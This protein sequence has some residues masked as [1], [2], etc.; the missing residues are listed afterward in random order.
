M[1]P[2]TPHNAST[3][4]WNLLRGLPYR[5]NTVAGIY[6]GEVWEHFEFAQAGALTRECHRVL[7]P[8]GV[9]RVCVPDGPT[10]WGRYLELYREQTAK[11]REARDATKLVAHTQMFFNEICTRKLILR[12][13]GHT[14]K[15]NFDEVQLIE[16]FEA[17]GFSAVERMPLHQSR[18]PGIE[19]VERSDFLIVEGVK[20]DPCDD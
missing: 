5:D 2:P 9:L 11:P 19:G 15:W 8:G 1:L 12:S 20:L 18:I 3:K 6:A 7:V 13:M 14:H 17:A 4:Y 10:F 16:M